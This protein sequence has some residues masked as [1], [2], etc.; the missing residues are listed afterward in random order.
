MLQV[1]HE[2]LVYM[3]KS[4][5]TNP[6]VMRWS[7]SLQPYKFRLDVIKGKDNIG[8]DMLSRLPC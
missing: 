4:K 1:D 3:S 6:R 8:A 5:L 2:P 7:L